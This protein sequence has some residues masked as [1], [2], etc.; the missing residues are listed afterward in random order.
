MAHKRGQ[1]FTLVEMIIVMMVAMIIM[2]FMAPALTPLFGSKGV[3]ASATKLKAVLLY[4]RSEA[5]KENVTVSV[6]FNN[7]DT[8][9]STTISR[10]WENNWYAIVKHGPTDTDPAVIYNGDTTVDNDTAEDD[11]YNYQQVGPRYYLEEG[12]A[13]LALSY[14]DG[15]DVWDTF[16]SGSPAWDAGS[17]GYTDASMYRIEFSPSGEATFV[18]GTA[19]LANGGEQ[20]VAITQEGGSSDESYYDNRLAVVVNKYTGLAEIKKAYP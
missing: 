15:T 18:C 11:D 4:A 1:G 13:F 12:C 14:S 17:C 5:A 7:V 8:V 19:G 10:D 16:T 9:G 6:V 3:S 20:V 2:G